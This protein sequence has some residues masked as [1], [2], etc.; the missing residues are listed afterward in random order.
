M[1]GNYKREGFWWKKSIRHDGHLH[2]YTLPEGVLNQI[3]SQ[4]LQGRFSF[5]SENGELQRF[6]VIDGCFNMWL[7]PSDIHRVD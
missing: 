6:V 3:F 2:L 5:Q 4:I 7:K 1:N